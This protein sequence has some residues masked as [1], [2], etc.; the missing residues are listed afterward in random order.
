MIEYKEFVKCVGKLDTAITTNDDSI[1]LK[2][3]LGNVSGDDYIVNISQK[4]MKVILDTI[5]MLDSRKAVR[6]FDYKV[7]C[8]LKENKIWMVIVSTSKYMTDE[9]FIK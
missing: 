6:G 4:N 1:T 9:D 7:G 2:V 5:S 8:L 3:L